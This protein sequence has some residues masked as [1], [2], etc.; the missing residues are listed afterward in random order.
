MLKRLF[1]AGVLALASS[2]M[3]QTIY[4]PLQYQFGRENK[5]FYGGTDPRVHGLANGFANPART[6]GRVQGYRFLSERRHVEREQPRIYSDLYPRE[7][8]WFYDYSADDA[9]NDARAMQPRYFRKGDL[10]KQTPVLPDG[11]RHVPAVPVPPLEFRSM[12]PAA[13]GQI[14]IRPSRSTGPVFRFPKDLLQKRLD[15]V[16][17]APQQRA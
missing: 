3:A 9:A 14:I 16:T 17:R 4:E 5:Y 13:P 2:S 12:N 11:T 6:Y 8:A 1:L 10:L 7:N 15:D